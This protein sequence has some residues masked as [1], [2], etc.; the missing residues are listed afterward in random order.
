ME[1]LYKKIPKEELKE[2]A[3]VVFRTERKRDPLGWYK[4]LS[5]KQQEVVNKILEAEVR[6]QLE[7]FKAKETRVIK[8]MTVGEVCKKTEIAEGLRQKPWWEDPESEMF[9][10]WTKERNKM[11]KKYKKYSKK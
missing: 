10:Q 1:K 5:S 3:E 4:T 7:K 9:K 6:E 2:A 11:N 8:G